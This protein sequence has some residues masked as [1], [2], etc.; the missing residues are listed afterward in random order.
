[1]I[2]YLYEIWHGIRV[3]LTFIGGGTVVAFFVWMYK[4]RQ[5]NFEDTVLGMFAKYQR[6]PWHTAEG[7]HNEYLGEV[8]GDVP[9]WVGSLPQAELKWRLRAIPY[10]FRHFWRR[11]FFLPSKKRVERTVLH[12]WKHGLLI[13]GH[14]DPKYYRLKP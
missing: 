14:D 7:I 4:R 10:Q 13:R 1:M 2:Q 9:L 11:N 6:E 12:L 3:V 5:E 8:V